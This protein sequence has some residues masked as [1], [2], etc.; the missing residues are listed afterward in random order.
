M[1]LRHVILTISHSHTQFFGYTIGFISYSSPLLAVSNIS[2]PL[3]C[4]TMEFSSFFIRYGTQ[5]K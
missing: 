5:G 2:L 1:T 4:Q 3:N